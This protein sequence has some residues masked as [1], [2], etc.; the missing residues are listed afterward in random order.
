MVAEAA[1][2]FS[3]WGNSGVACN[4]PPV[5]LEAHKSVVSKHQS[6]PNFDQGEESF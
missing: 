6:G 2:R 3:S 5:R 4:P 1:G